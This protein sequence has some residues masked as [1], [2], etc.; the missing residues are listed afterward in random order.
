M[1]LERVKEPY[2]ITHLSNLSNE[3]EKGVV[4]KEPYEITHLSNQ[5]E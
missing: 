4:V 3:R 5:K 2:E 1:G